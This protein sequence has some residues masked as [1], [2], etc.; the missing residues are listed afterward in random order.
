MH[1]QSHQYTQDNK[2]NPLPSP[3]EIPWQSISHTPPRTSIHT[4]VDRPPV[5]GDNSALNLLE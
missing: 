5:F 2:H 4:T 3:K 1:L